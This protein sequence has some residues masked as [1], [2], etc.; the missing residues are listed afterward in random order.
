[1]CSAEGALDIARPSTLSERFSA[2]R[3]CSPG[4]LLARSGARAIRCPAAAMSSHGSGD[5]HLLALGALGA[6][7]TADRTYRCRAPGGL[8]GTEFHLDEAS[9]TGHPR[10]APRRSRW[11]RGCDHPPRGLRAPTSRICAGSSWRWAC[12]IDGVG[13]NLLRVHG[14][15][16]LR[17][18]TH[19]CC[20]DPSRSPRSSAWRAGGHG[21]RRHDHRLRAQRPAARRCSRSRASAVRVAIAG[22]DVRVPPGQELRS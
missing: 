5:S 2:P 15:A 17:A 10:K 8:E 22:R 3:S 13:S 14:Q 18:A 11:P 20:P 21:R 6:Q 1:M 4:P 9:V 12:D 16:A 7:V 19:V